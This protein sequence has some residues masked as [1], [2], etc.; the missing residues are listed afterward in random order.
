MGDED[1]YSVIM[2]RTHPDR[3]KYDMLHRIRLGNIPASRR[4]RSGNEA[5]R[6][7]LLIMEN[8]RFLQVYLVSISMLLV[9]LIKIYMDKENDSFVNNIYVAI[10][11]ITI[12]VL[13]VE[14]IGWLYDG[15]PGALAHWIVTV[16]D[17]LLLVLILVPGMLW[18]IYADF[19][20]YSSYRRVKV[21]AGIAAVLLSYFMALSFSAPFNQL[22]FYIDESN[23]YHHGRW[24][25][26]IQVLYYFFF[27][28]AFLIILVNRK[29]IPRQ[30]VA[31]LLFFAIPPF[32]GTVLQM[33]FYGLSL[34]WSGVSISL[35]ILY[36]YLQN[37]KVG[38]DYL[39]G[40]FNRRKLDLHL[41][42]QVNKVTPP[43]VLAVLMLDVDHFK[44]INDT[45][46][47]EVGDRALEQC[48]VI[49]RKCFHQ[50]DFIARY[51]GDEFVVVLYID[52]KESIQCVIERIK[53]TV[54]EMGTSVDLPYPLSF[55]IGYA[56]YPEDGE[57][58]SQLIKS[59]DAR[60][61]QD[62]RTKDPE[63]K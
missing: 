38:K 57:N 14:A 61:Y 39:T 26:Q 43:R 36:V 9:I 18:M 62:K 33:M 48:G 4:Q 15:E 27:V 59:A 44:V 8:L 1:N 52:R 23:V 42:D 31:P 34:A 40:L 10:L 37:Q 56:L 54:E 35:L 25:W 47:H 21:I 16:S 55:S 28:Y 5:Q 50:D 20:I 41:K 49:L 45:W 22:L 17:A 58:D 51:A 32:V 30:I 13:I 53:K 24:Y 19:Q 3:E 11:W 7:E 6:R 63:F 12:G 60:M 29:H 2:V 46:G